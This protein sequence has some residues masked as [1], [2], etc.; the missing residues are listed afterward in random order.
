MSERPTLLVIGLP[1]S[2]SDE[3]VVRFLERFLEQEEPGT[4]WR[5]IDRIEH[6]GGDLEE[7]GKGLPTAEA[8][9]SRFPPKMRPPGLDRALGRAQEDDR[10]ELYTTAEKN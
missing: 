6:V 9:T 3:K 7:D 10:D 5:C 2:E 8:R 1:S 4:A